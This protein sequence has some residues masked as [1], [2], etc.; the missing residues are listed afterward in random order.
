MADQVPVISGSAGASFDVGSTSLLNLSGALSFSDADPGDLL[1]TSITSRKIRYSSAAGIDQ[2]ALLSADQVAMAENAFSVAVGSLNANH[3]NSVW[4]FNLDAGQLDFLGRLETLTLTTTV[5]VDDGSG[6]TATKDV[7]I[8]LRGAN[9]A[10]AFVPTASIV[11]SAVVHETAASLGSTALHVTQGALGFTDADI[12]DRHSISVVARGT[13][14]LGTLTPTLTADTTGGQ[15]GSVTWSF[16]VA[17]QKLDFLSAGQQ[18]AQTYTITIADNKGGTTSQD[19][20]VTLVGIEDLPTVSGSQATTIYNPLVAVPGALLVRHG[21]LSATDV[22]QTGHL[23]VSVG[24][25]RVDY[26]DAAGIDVSS[27]PSGD[28]TSQQA[29]A[30][31]FADTLGQYLTIDTSAGG[32]AATARWTYAVDP[33]VLRFLAPHETITVTADVT[34]QDRDAA[35][36]PVGAPQVKPVTVTLVGANDDAQVRT[37]TSSIIN[38]TFLSDVQADFSIG[39]QPA[40]GNLRPASTLTAQDGID[41]HLP[42]TVNVTRDGATFDGVDFRGMQVRVFA[43]NVT[44]TNCLFDASGSQGQSVLIEREGYSNLTIDHCTFDGLRRTDSIPDMVES[45]GANATITNNVFVNMPVDGLLVQGGTV[46]GNYFA[47]AGYHPGAHS[48]GIWVPKTVSPVLIDNNVIDWRPDPAAAVLTNNAIRVSSEL[49]D[50]TG[51]T[52]ENNVL[53]GGNYTITTTKDATF[54]HTTNQMGMMSDVEII[55]NIIDLGRSGSLDPLGRPSDLVVDGNARLSGGGAPFSDASLAGVPDLSGLAVVGALATSGADVTVADPSRY[56]VGGALSDIIHA[57][58]GYNI[59]QGDGSR[60]YVSGGSGTNV[61]FFKSLS[62]AHDWIQHFNDA[63]DKIDIASAIELLPFDLKASDWNWVGTGQFT[64]S[65][66][67][68]RYTPGIDQSHIYIDLNGDFIPDVQIDVSGW[69]D[70][71]PDQFI[72]ARPTPD[73]TILGNLWAGQGFDLATDTLTLPF[74]VASAP[75]V[76]ADHDVFLKDL[77][78]ALLSIDGFSHYVFSDGTINES[79]SDPLVDYLF[80][81]TEYRTVWGSGIDAATD[82]H[83]MGWQSGRDPDAYFSTSGYLA[84]YGNRIGALVD[85]LTEYDSVGWKLGYNPSAD[86]DTKTYLLHN[87]DVAASGVDPLT[88]YLTVGEAE[89]LQVYGAIGSSIV[90]GFDRDFYLLEN[91]AAA[92]SGVDPYTHYELV[93]WQQ[94]ENPNAFFDVKYYL[95]TYSD[96]AAAGIDPLHDYMTTG[97]KLGRDPSADFDTELYLR[98]NPDVA[99]SGQNPLQ[100]FLAQGA[101]EGRLAFAVGSTFTDTPPIAADDLGAFR[102]KPHATFSSGSGGV[103]AND[104]DADND[105]LKVIAVDE[106]GFSVGQ[107][108]H[109]KNGTIVINADGSYTYTLDANVGQIHHVAFDEFTYVVSDQHGG[110]NSANLT[111]ALVNDANGSVAAGTSPVPMPGPTMLSQPLP[112]QFVFKET[113][114]APALLNSAFDPIGLA[115]H[116]LDAPA[117]AAFDFGQL[118]TELVHLLG[119]PAHSAASD[120]AAATAFDMF[121]QAMSHTTQSLT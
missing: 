78:G 111:I 63:T 56:I 80:Y 83:A 48:D 75:L 72:V 50:V 26:Q 13:G 73:L 44:F 41:V 28:L 39:V 113:A 46:A 86:F 52:I 88:H 20:T 29:A 93:G 18:L 17:D 62:G 67:Q 1:V 6:G 33:A 7:V 43:N 114:P 16:A 87:P 112:D 64:G 120:H 24:S 71:T 42:I 35:D 31:Q 92:T 11:N 12:T 55:D 58:D 45:Y 97:W 101:D 91:S 117:A 15:T 65:Q 103:L 90:D 84:A 23:S 60:D 81:Y 19:V 79:A 69:H 53:L 37:Y 102:V 54:T 61:F 49:G 108:V 47:N 4:T 40:A 25:V 118:A 89:G 10:P 68:I 99:A 95:Q 77:D 121:A 96:V 104:K 66:F 51:V 22:D 34:F 100:Q 30:L 76:V 57:G 32:D 14:Y 8:T 106:N 74:S 36:D 105:P 2:T 59:I 94:G 27:L 110:N 21:V 3:G 115:S 119:D 109:G 82:Y 98:A 107:P 5:Q 38:R 70:F 85:P 116:L 9:D